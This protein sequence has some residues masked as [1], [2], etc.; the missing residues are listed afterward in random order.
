MATLGATIY[1]WA[2]PC[3]VLAVFAYVATQLLRDYRRAR[4]GAD[5]E[6]S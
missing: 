6:G 2:G 5:K 1:L 3:L 4:L